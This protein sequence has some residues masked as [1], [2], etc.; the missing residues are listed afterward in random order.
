MPPLNDERNTVRKK[1][2]SLIIQ[3]KVFEAVDIFKEDFEN[4][5]GIIKKIN[6]VYYI[7]HQTNVCNRGN[8]EES[9]LALIAYLD[10][11]N[12]LIIKADLLY[13]KAL[14]AYYKGD[15]T[16]VITTINP[17]AAS[18][19]DAHQE[20]SAQLG[21]NHLLIGKAYWKLGHTLFA[22]LHYF[23]AYSFLKDS[24]IWK[25]KVFELIARL[26]TE[27]LDILDPETPNA[28]TW[29]NKAE[30]HLKNCV[31]GHSNYN[32]H[33]FFTSICNYRTLYMLEFIKS[34][35]IASKEEASNSSSIGHIETRI[36]EILEAISK[37]KIDDK[38]KKK[39]SLKLAEE[40][41]RKYQGNQYE[42]RSRAAFLKNQGLHALMKGKWDGSPECIDE[43]IIFFQEDLKIREKIFPNSQHTTISRNYIIQAEAYLTKYK[44]TNEV[45]DLDKAFTLVQKA[46]ELTVNNFFS[47]GKN[48]PILNEDN[49][50]SNVI[51]NYNLI[52]ILRVKLDIFEDMLEGGFEKKTVDLAKSTVDLALEVIRIIRMKFKSELAN[53]TFS[54]VAKKLYTSCLNILIKLKNENSTA[55]CNQKILNI[56]EE[57]SY[58]SINQNFIEEA[59]SF[60]DSEKIIKK[61]SDSIFN[62]DTILLENGIN[63]MLKYN[64]FNIQLDNVANASMVPTTD[65]IQAYFKKKRSSKVHLAFVSFFLSR[66]KLFA[67]IIKEN[68]SPIIKELI[69]GRDNIL[70]LK[71][72]IEI[73]RSTINNDEEVNFDIAKESSEQLN[74]IL[75]R[76]LQA[77]LAKI[78]YLIIIPDSHLAQIPFEALIIDSPN[79]EYPKYL[80]EKYFVTYHHSISLLFKS[81]KE[82]QFNH[83]EKLSERLLFTGIGNLLKNGQP[84]ENP[85]QWKIRDEIRDIKQI[86]EKNGFKNVVGYVDDTTNYPSLEGFSNPDKIKKDIKNSQIVHL[87]SHGPDNEDRGLP[88]NLYAPK[89]FNKLK[90]IVLNACS[91]GVGQIITGEGAKG[92]GRAFLRDPAIKNV[93]Y[94]LSDIPDGEAYKLMK[95]FYH[96]L[97]APPK[98]YPPFSFAVALCFAKRELIKEWKE[99]LD[100]TGGLVP[101]IC[102]S[103]VFIGNPLDGIDDL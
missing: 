17:K 22:M 51:S 37:D 64:C 99:I 55:S 87:V 74:K 40:S 36:E 16:T 60:S 5:E 94:T 76:S 68:G 89:N 30:S 41:L 70:E 50:E 93:I 42:N 23:K 96:F 75:F 44:L 86:L 20:D 77:Y 1:S 13:A 7:F 88:N 6:L 48:N 47:S 19:F 102:L 4:T 73:F 26:K 100:G 11:D 39:Y 81:I 2:D 72:Q 58:Y 95:F 56:F 82:H 27:M 92:L 43:A 15:Y 65:E 14:I 53:L 33:Y 46:L 3:N 54:S 31:K 71:Q 12:P 9:K 25:V 69:D 67:F 80:V 79:K 91:T 61:I 18:L 63:N 52:H 49:F 98:D 10:D 78:N 59:F 32:A 84:I 83:S 35:G 57:S 66:N 103:H 38:D 8:L 24:C 62:N 101:L 85:E 45:Q 28:L 34:D 29:L 90:L 97:S 21:Q